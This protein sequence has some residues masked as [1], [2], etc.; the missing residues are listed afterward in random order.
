MEK[1]YTQ[2]YIG[3]GKG[4]TTAAI[5]LG[6]RA[7]GAGLRVSMIQ[8]LKGMY[9]CEEKILKNLD[10]FSLYRFQHSESFYSSASEEEKK[11]ISEDFKKS[12]EKVYEILQNQEC[13]MLIL[14]EI[15]DCIDVGLLEEV[16]IINIID[17]KPKGIE[18]ILTGH[19]EY[20]NIIDKVDL[21]T[22]MTPRK[23]YMDAGVKARN[24]IE[25]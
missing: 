16:E 2:L 21:V 15:I 9:S 22:V 14:D 6:V 25:F 19:K 3:Y 12:I 17:N 23:H 24:G 1:M 5:G 10:N 4:K 20:K 11:G 7:L 8:F 13:D 18:L